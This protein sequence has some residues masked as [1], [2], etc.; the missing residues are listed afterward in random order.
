ML[1]DEKSGDHKSDTTHPED[2]MSVCTEWKSIQQFVE[3]FL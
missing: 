2:D 3:T 1:L